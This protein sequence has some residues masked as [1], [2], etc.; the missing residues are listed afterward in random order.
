MTGERA[1]V[2]A[3]AALRSHAGRL[4]LD[5]A[6]RPST[7]PRWAAYRADLRATA[8]DAEQLAAAIAAGDRVIVT[9]EQY[10]AAVR[11]LSRELHPPGTGTA[12]A[13]GDVIVLATRTGKDTT[14]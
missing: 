13:E 9:R 11:E 1:L 5:A 2:L 10:Q 6:G 7:G 3:A 4:R 12:P 14:S 8:A